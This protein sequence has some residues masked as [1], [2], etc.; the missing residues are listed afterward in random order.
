MWYGCYFHLSIKQSSLVV[1]I[2]HLPKC[3]TFIILF[4]YIFIFILHYK[5]ILV[6][7]NLLC[8]FDVYIFNTIFIPMS[9]AGTICPII[10]SVW[11]AASQKLFP[12]IQTLPRLLT[13]TTVS[14]ALVVS[15]SDSSHAHTAAWPSSVMN[16]ALDSPP[17]KS[18]S[19]PNVDS[20]DFK[21][22]WDNI[23]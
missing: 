18:S 19:V 23:L 17:S 15:V 3:W 13:L 10:R 1:Y 14:M 2:Q 9:V 16:A 8:S 11:L 5:K 12:D 6:I 22:T 21:S 4:L 7:I 20:N